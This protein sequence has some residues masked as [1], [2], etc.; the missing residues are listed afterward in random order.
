MAGGD[1]ASRDERTQAGVA[2]D[3]LASM[4]P[5]FSSQ[6]PAP[7]AKAQPGPPPA[8]PGRYRV[9]APIAAGGMG[10]V[11]RVLDTQL[12][13]VLAAKVLPGAMSQLAG[14]RAR[15]LA[16]ARVTAQLDHPGIVALHDQGETGD[17]SLWFTMKEVRG[18]TLRRVIDD[19]HGASTA[20]GWGETS[21]GWSLRRLVEALAR[22]CEAVASAHERGILHRDLKPANVMV[23]AFGEVLVMDWGLAGRRA[24]D[25]DQPSQIARTRERTGLQTRD[26]AVMGT[27]GYMAPE[28]ARSERAAQGPWTDVHGLGAMLYDVLVGRPPFA[29]VAATLAGRP[30]PMDL[31]TQGGPAVPPA[32]QAICEQALAG[33]PGARHADAGVLATALRAWLDGSHRRTQAL[34]VVARARGLV[35]RLQALRASSTKHRDR[36]LDILTDLSPTAPLDQKRPAWDHQDRAERLARE[37]AVG[38]AEFLQ[39]ARSA[40]EIVPDLA[41]G[42]GLLAQHYAGRLIEA[43]ALRRHSDAARLEALLRSHDRGAF[44][45]FLSGEGAVTL[46][47]DPAGAVVSARPMVVVDRQLVPGAPVALGRTPLR[48]ARLGRGSWLLTVEAEGCEAVR[49]PVF[50]GRGERWDGVR[51]GGSRPAVV[52]LPALGSL[53]AED[54][55]VPGGW[56]LAGGDPDADDALARGPRWVDGFVMKRFPVTR[57]EYRVFLNDLVAQGRADE[58][59]AHAPR[60]VQSQG[61]ERLVFPRGPDGRFGPEPDGPADQDRWPVILVTWWGASAYAAWMTE[62]T[63]QGWRLPSEVE[64]EKAARGVDGRHYVWGDHFDATWCLSLDSQGEVTALAPVEAWATDVSVY[65]VRGLAGGVR[66]WCREVW[67]LRGAVGVDQVAGVGPLSEDDEAYRVIRGAAWTSVANQ[68]RAAARFVG[69]PGVAMGTVGVRLVRAM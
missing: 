51:P 59:L 25:T 65:G 13:R 52:R 38:E 40:L 10:E 1:D 22:V 37:A 20:G 57:G 62:R 46:V 24:N 64:W 41:E 67:T 8:L 56:F 55:L 61:G 18:R 31:A 42:H 50:L 12:D 33:D 60:V 34:A 2:E 36:A 3:S 63:G 54:C 48:D 4:E 58:A 6:D 28:Q 26:G 19:V 11:W 45:G 66:D 15:F 53:G 17:G 49:Y 30:L 32:L 7:R 47:T 43:E 44:A 21:D 39:V 9:L 29:S 35:P 27:P 69:R 16:E 5:W 23:G 14:P 68:V